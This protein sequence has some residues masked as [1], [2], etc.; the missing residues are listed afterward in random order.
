MSLIRHF[1]TAPKIHFKYWKNSNICCKIKIDGVLIKKVEG[2]VSNTSQHKIWTGMRVFFSMDFGLLNTKMIFKKFSVGLFS[3]CNFFKLFHPRTY[4]DN[5]WLFF[6][7]GWLFFF[8]LNFQGLVLPN[9]ET[10]GTETANCAN[11]VSFSFVF[12]N[13]ASKNQIQQM[14][15]KL[16]TLKIHNFCS[17]N[18]NWANLGSKNLS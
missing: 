3:R 7:L 4:F 10:W 8:I 14:A 18:P 16:E 12:K 6:A 9:F 1:C 13:F 11:F 17:V 2:R 15:I 5:F